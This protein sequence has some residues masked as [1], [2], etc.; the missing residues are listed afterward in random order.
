MGGRYCGGHAVEGNDGVKAVVFDL[1]GTLL[2][3]EAAVWSALTESTAAIAGEPMPV[4]GADRAMAR[5]LGEVRTLRLISVDDEEL[6]HRLYTEFRAR[7]RQCAPGRVHIR[8]GARS[9]LASLRRAGIQIAVVSA[10]D[11]GRVREDLHRLELAALVDTV[12]TGGDFG[13]PAPSPEPLLRCLHE[14]DRPSSEV[15]LV[16]GTEDDVIGADAADLRVIMMDNGSHEHVTEAPWRMIRSL[17][18]VAP[19]I[20]V[21]SDRSLAPEETANSRSD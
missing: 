21:A 9:L 17:G 12:V 8:D 10:G 13:S 11:D 1:D 3:S 6:F 5:K 20:G 16:T 4:S 2:D 15:V 14:L 18:A 19:T 7:Y